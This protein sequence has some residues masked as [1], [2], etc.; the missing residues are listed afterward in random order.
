MKKI[1]VLFLVLTIFTLPFFGEFFCKKYDLEIGKWLRIEEGP[2]PV[3]VQDIKFEFPSYIGPKKLDIKGL[4]QAIVDFKNYGDVP[5]KVKL[6]LALFDEENN[7][8]ACGTTSSKFVHTK[9][10]KEEKATI[11][12]SNVRSKIDKAKYFYLTV[13]TE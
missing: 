8:V 13:E 2:K 3:V 4:P 1:L 6:A 5:L 11:V 9:G 12:F 10:G 7:L